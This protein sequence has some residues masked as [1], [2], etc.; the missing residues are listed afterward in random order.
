MHKGEIW[1][2]NLTDGKGHEQTGHRPGLIIGKGN[3]LITVI[4]ITSNIERAN[5]SFTEIIDC[6]P[7]NGLNTDSVALIFQIL[8][9]DESRFIKKLGEI[10]KEK[11]TS[12]HGILIE[13]TK[14]K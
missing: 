3:G 9:L 1:L 11:Y 14:L 13:M 8:S 4:P 12:I 6:A 10:P 7:Q 5:L 2:I